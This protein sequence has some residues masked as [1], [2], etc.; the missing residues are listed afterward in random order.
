VISYDGFIR[1]RWHAHAREQEVNKLSTFV[2]Q[3]QSLDKDVTKNTQALIEVLTNMYSESVKYAQFYR[4]TQQYAQKYTHTEHVAN[5]VYNELV[6]VE[7]A[8]GIRV[9]EL[10]DNIS[11]QITRLQKGDYEEY[12]HT[13]FLDKKHLSVLK[14][15]VLKPMNPII[16]A[17]VII[18]LIALTC[19][20]APFLN[21]NYSFITTVDSAVEEQFEKM[22][23]INILSQNHA[24]TVRIQ[25]FLLSLYPNENILQRAD[26]Q[27]ILVT[28][29]LFSQKAAGHF[30]P[31]IQQIFLDAGMKSLDFDET[32]LHELGHALYTK[33]KTPNIYAQLR[34]I[35]DAAGHTDL[36]ESRYTHYSVSG[37]ENDDEFVTRLY[38]VRM[39]DIR[40]FIEQT[41]RYPRSSQ[42]LVEVLYSDSINKDTIRDMIDIFIQYKLYPSGI[43]ASK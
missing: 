20:S 43:V 40:D 38:V 30:I 5:H 26:I 14:K 3:K 7:Q 11:V 39:Y 32:L 28:K 27:T 13:N 9:Q 22:Y 37:S 34:N 21:T 18:S 17:G 25:Q 1:E 24:Q 19:V 15:Y 16:K 4:I 33:Y 31:G 6:S 42:E 29:P 2:K 35:T 23:N 10:P 36:V 12:L 41:K 8:I